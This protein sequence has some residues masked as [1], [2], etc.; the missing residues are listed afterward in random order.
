MKIYKFL[1]SFTIIGICA[2]IGIG[3][4]YIKLPYWFILNWVIS[5]ICGV[6]ALMWVMQTISYIVQIC[7]HHETLDDGY[8]EGMIYWFFPTDYNETHTFKN[9]HV[10]QTEAQKI[11]SVVDTVKS[12]TNRTKD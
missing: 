3:V 10:T 5:F 2:L 8:T 11:G 6:V 9:I 12:Y 1:K 4:W 7:N